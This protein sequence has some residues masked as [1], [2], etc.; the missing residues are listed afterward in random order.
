MCPFVC[1]NVIGNDCNTF[2]YD[3]TAKQCNVGRI[4]SNSTS[5]FIAAKAMGGKTFMVDSKVVKKNARK[6]MDVFSLTNL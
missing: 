6:G 3:K 1:K 2:T 4:V 5:N